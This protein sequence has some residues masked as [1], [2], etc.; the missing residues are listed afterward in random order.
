MIRARDLTGYRLY[1]GMSCKQ[2]VAI[3]R[4]VYEGDIASGVARPRGALIQD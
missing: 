1:S 2:C 3:A 4:H